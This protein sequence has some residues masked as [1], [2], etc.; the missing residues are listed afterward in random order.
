MASAK[1]FENDLSNNPPKQHFG[2]D[3]SF[4]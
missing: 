4:S 1:Y 2:T 3:S